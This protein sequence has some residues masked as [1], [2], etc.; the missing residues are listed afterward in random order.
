MREIIPG[1]YTW[2]WLSPRHGYNFNGYA[3][4]SAE[5]LIVIDPVIMEDADMDEL[6]KLGT[7]A[8]IILTNKD[9]ERIAY[10]IRDRFGAK[11]HIHKED[12][13]LLKQVPD[14]KFD[15]GDIL[16]GNLRAINVSD[17]KSPGETA[18]LLLRGKGIL[19]IGDAIIG[20][21]KGEFSL[22]PMDK[23][24]NP[25]RAKESIK[26]LLEYDYDTVLV[27]DGESVLE[28]GKEAILRF[29]RRENVHLTLPVR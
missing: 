9:H 15:D 18:L 29:L 17:N 28:G 6:Q 4:N 5:G 8:L 27:G 22:L 20:W 16:P 3:F 1:I 23:Y 19:F 24:Q 2:S 21:P 7:P 10:E 14:H 13:P 25:H 12:A 26:V 11:I